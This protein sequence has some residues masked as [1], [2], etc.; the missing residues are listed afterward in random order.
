MPDCLSLCECIGAPK[1]MTI[2]AS[3]QLW[4]QHGW[5]KL[6]KCIVTRVGN[7]DLLSPKD[8]LRTLILPD[9]QSGRPKGDV[10]PVCSDTKYV[11]RA[12][13][14]GERNFSLCSAR[15]FPSEMYNC[16]PPPPSALSVWNAK[17]TDLPRPSSLARSLLIYSN[18]S[19]SLSLELQRNFT[20]EL[21]VKVIQNHEF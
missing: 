18:V 9:P 21:F 13:K 17:L 8:F 3:R 19:K 2:T 12:E 7:A 14:G 20:L 1:E 5:A 6:T 15:V 4:L 10:S 11:Y 16:K